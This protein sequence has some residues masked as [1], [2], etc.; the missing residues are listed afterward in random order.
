MTR[1]LLYGERGMLGTAIRE[2]APDDIE[3]VDSRARFTYDLSADGGVLLDTLYEL[4]ENVT[5]VINCVGMR[6]ENAW[7]PGWMA[8]INGT[9]PHL[10]A[11]RWTTAHIPVI[12]VSTDCVLTLDSHYARTKLA[13][14]SDD[15]INVRTS[16]VGPRHGLWAW[17]V[18]QVTKGQLVEGWVNAWWSGSTV[19]AVASALLELAG[20]PGDARTLNLAT[21]GPISKYLLLE[22]LI[23]QLELEVPM[24]WVPEPHIDRRMVP[25]IVLPP[26]AEALREMVP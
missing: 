20:D 7:H 24:K 17:L 15:A 16:F 12:H 8:Y 6:P 3:V 2:Q 9:L 18:E 19:N 21:E 26:F 4:G 10:I 22:S 5:A 23:E 25:D 13:G 14:E 1:V 11:A